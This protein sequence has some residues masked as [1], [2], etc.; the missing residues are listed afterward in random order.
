MFT[1]DSNGTAPISLVGLVGGTMAAA[2]LL[3]AFGPVAS[4]GSTAVS[5]WPRWFYLLA[6]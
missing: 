5:A 2:L 6:S 4:S 3:M 1:G